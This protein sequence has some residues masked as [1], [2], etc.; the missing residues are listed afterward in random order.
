MGRWPK[1]PPH[2]LG[3]L[4][5]EPPL[6]DVPVAVGAECPDVDVL[7]ACVDREDPIVGNAEV[8]G[9]SSFRILFIEVEL[10][11]RGCE[12]VGA[13]RPGRSAVDIGVL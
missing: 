7:D 10:L 4:L 11:T 5:L 9:D 3:L 1:P 8:V 13:V 12:Q 2:S 6:F